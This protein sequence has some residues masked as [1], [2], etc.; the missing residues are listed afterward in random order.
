MSEKKTDPGCKLLHH[1]TAVSSEPRFVVFKMGTLFPSSETLSL[2]LP[3]LAT[4][5]DFAL[6]QVPSA[7][8]TWRC[9]EASRGFWG[10]PLDLQLPPLRC[11]C[12]WETSYFTPG[13]TTRGKRLSERPDWA[14]MGRNSD[15]QTQAKRHTA[16]EMVED[17]AMDTAMPRA[18]ES[19]RSWDF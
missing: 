6:W 14:E 15:Q 9:S 10:L 11:L 2:A 1:L 5:P 16:S 13:S 17:T 19:L 12:R 4:P 3:P 18:E 7:V 8:S